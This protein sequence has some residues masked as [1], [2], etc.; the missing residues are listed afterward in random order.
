M[1]IVTNF[2]ADDAVQRSLSLPCAWVM[3]SLWK[4]I[5]DYERVGMSVAMCVLDIE[6]RSN[7]ANSI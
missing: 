4:G 6:Y 3:N 2:D 7:T 5:A 1:M